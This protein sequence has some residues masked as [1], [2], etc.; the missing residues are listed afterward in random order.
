M[1]LIEAISLMPSVWPERK[2][3]GITLYSMSTH[4]Y[5]YKTKHDGRA[6]ML[7]NVIQEGAQLSSWLRFFMVLVSDSRK[8]PG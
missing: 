8:I 5:R 3:K 7:Q 4:Y 1:P 2:T 6:V